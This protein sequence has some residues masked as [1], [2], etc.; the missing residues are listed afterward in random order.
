ME[1]AGRG[2]RSQ[3][4]DIKYRRRQKSENM[5]AAAGIDPNRPKLCKRKLQLVIV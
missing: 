4:R 2:F 1:C 3:H 5:R